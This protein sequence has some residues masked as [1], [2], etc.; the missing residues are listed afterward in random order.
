[1]LVRI[2]WPECEYR[3]WEWQETGLDAFWVECTLEDAREKV[4]PLLAEDERTREALDNEL[5]TC[6]EPRVIARIA[7]VYKGD[8]V[9]ADSPMLFFL[10]TRDLSS[11]QPMSWYYPFSGQWNAYCPFREIEPVSLAIL[12]E[13]ASL[14]PRPK[15]GVSQEDQVSPKLYRA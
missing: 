1:M 12:D 5:R 11:I 14:D 9:S 13:L 6:E 3:N 7:E 2:Y 10:V 8:L 4:I 15:N